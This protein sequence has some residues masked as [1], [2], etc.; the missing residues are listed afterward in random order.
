MILPTMNR[1]T[2]TLRT[3]KVPKKYFKVSLKQEI[4]VKKKIS[5]EM[6]FLSTCFHVSSFVILLK[7][8]HFFSLPIPL[9]L[10]RFV[11]VQNLFMRSFACTYTR[12]GLPHWNQNPTGTM[13]V[14]FVTF[15]PCH[16][17]LLRRSCLQSSVATCEILSKL[18]WF[19]SGLIQ[20]GS[21]FTDLLR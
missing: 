5:L 9:T 16:P 14:L 12:L 4:S 13:K 20:R 1:K 8:F 15:W 17:K 19:Q 18:N 10:P 7:F 2:M 11:S 3:D 21:C 6:E